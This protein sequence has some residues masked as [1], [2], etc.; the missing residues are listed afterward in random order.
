MYTICDN[1]YYKLGI[2]SQIELLEQT[3]LNK[4]IYCGFNDD[5]D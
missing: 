5:Q 4:K 3:N 1:A 2:V